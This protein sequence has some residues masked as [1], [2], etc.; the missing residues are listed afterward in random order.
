MHGGD[1]CQGRR[2]IAREC[3]QGHPQALDD[4]HDG[5]DFVGFP[6]VRQREHRVIAR[7]HADV[8]VTRLAGMDEEGRGPGAGQ[9]G[10]D[11]AADV[12]RLAHAGHHDAAPAL[13]ANSAGPCK[14]RSQAGHL[15]PQPVDFDA[16]GLTA[17]FDQ[18]FVRE[19]ER[20]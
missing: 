20:R 19:I 7:D 4:G 15:G 12:S 9:R 16:Q 10:G 8:A 3:D 13:Q 5:E 11:L 2:R 6:G 14:L 1:P 18:R 17:E